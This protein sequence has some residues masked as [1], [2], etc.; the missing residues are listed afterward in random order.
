MKI[1]INLTQD[2]IDAALFAIDGMQDNE[3]DKGMQEGYAAEW[4]AAAHDTLMN[5]SEGPV[6]MD[7]EEMAVIVTACSSYTG[8]SE[9]DDIP[10]IANADRL[11][12]R[13]N[14]ITVSIE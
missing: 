5:A 4:A 14:Q 1:R 13:L 3:R 11:Y 7:V 9:Q 6:E 2:E 12:D 8:F 10:D